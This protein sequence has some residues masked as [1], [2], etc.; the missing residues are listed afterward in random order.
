M[1]ILSMQGVTH[2]YNEG[3]PGQSKAIDNINIEVVGQT[4]THNLKYTDENLLSTQK[5]KTLISVSQGY[6][7]CSVLPVN[8]KA[9]LT[10]NE[11]EE[12]QKIFLDIYH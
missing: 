8:E 4:R 10:I 1:P 7:K 3:M 11:D 2:L 12:I 5:N 6:T 9:L